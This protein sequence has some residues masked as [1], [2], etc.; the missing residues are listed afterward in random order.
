MSGIDGRAEQATFT[1]VVNEEH[2]DLSQEDRDRIYKAI[3]EIAGSKLRGQGEGY[4]LVSYMTWERVASEV[5]D[6]HEKYQ[7]NAISAVASDMA[8]RS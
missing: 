7:V 4:G 8:H 5:I 1:L 2:V 3:Q 6:A